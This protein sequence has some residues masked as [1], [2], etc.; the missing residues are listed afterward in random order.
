MHRSFVIACLLVSVSSQ[1]FAADDIIAS[2]R[3]KAVIVY[4]NRAT[5][6]REAVV[7]VPAG[8]HMIVFNG[9]SGNLLPD[10]LR[11][12]GHAAADVK[13][14]AVVSRLVPGDTLVAPREKELT[15]QLETLQDKS[16]S[17]ASEKQA[18]SFKQTFINTLGNQAALHSR[19]GIA[20]N[21][22]KPA[23]WMDEVQTA[24]TGLSETLKAEDQG[25]IALR[26][27]NRQIAKVQQ[28]LQQ[29]QTGQRSTYQVMIPVD[30]SVATKLTVDLSYQLPDITWTPLYDARLD[31]AKGTL[32]LTQYGSVH[33]SSGE[34]WN[35]V[36]LT[37]S[38]AQP[39]L[40]TGLPDLQTMWMNLDQ[41][42]QVM[43]GGAGGTTFSTIADNIVT[44]SGVLTF[45]APSVFN[46]RDKHYAPP[47]AERAATFVPAAVETGGFVSE[48]KIPGP[49]T[50][51]ADGTESKLMIGT[52][53]ADSEMRILV[54][55][56]LSNEAYLVAHTT[57]KGEAPILPGPVSLFRDEA[58]VGQSNIP[59][60][61][62]G[63]ENDLA[64]G[65]DDQVSVKRHVLKD[66]TGEGGMIARS[67]VLERD[68]VTEL[69]NLHKKKVNV[70]VEEAIPVAQ[71]GKVGAEILTGQTTP[72]YEE[73]KDNIKGLLEWKAPLD[74]TQK[75]EIKLGWKVTWPKDSEITGL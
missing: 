29:L 37:L 68:F 3:L 30:A 69:Q 72:G 27:L 9:L 24:Y 64:F 52:L 18:L 54:K 57:L 5:L 63:Q 65:A 46:G 25:D 62:P 32:E 41:G 60:L 48:Y 1:A 8:A 34:D 44:T 53:D 31:T 43:G 61:R 45:S 51:K 16:R 35:D 75:S 33:Q 6:T 12:K 49:A 13:F 56:Q 28:E 26:D 74:P 36:E 50:V 42:G 7:D 4:T 70:I 11:A 17:V 40:G 19:D 67:N 22:A 38:T 20:T 10:S 71:D 21:E 47:P 15:D 73:D 59:L 39:Q 14:G 58:F 66:E 2:G 55:P 23:Q